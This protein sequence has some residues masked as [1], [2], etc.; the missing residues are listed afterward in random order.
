[1]DPLLSRLLL[2]TAELKDMRQSLNVLSPAIFNLCLECSEF[3]RPTRGPDTTIYTFDELNMQKNVF[4]V[5]NLQ[6]LLNGTTLFPF[7]YPLRRH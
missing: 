3:N 5:E 2:K 6:T 4:L 7:Y 1:M